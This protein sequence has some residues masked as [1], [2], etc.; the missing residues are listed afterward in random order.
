[1]PK[2]TLVITHERSGT[3]LLINC[4]NYDQKG[5]FYTVGYSENKKDFHLNGYKH[6]TYKDIMSNAYLP[7]SVSKSH[8]QAEFMEE[9]LYFLFKKYSVI[10]VKREVKDVLSSYYKFMPRPDQI[11]A[12]PSLEEWIFCKPDDIGRKFFNPYFPDPHVITEPENYVHRWFL[13]TNGWLKH[14]DKM[15]VVNYEDMLND[16][17]NQKEKIE[18]YIGKKIAPK[19]PDVHDKSL[20]N[21]GPVKGKIG[22][23]KEVMSVKLIEKIEDC[24]SLYNIKETNEKG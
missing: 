8:H 18:N 23:H 3:H 20:P 11:P 4:I 2:P 16:Y 9:Y 22:G 17:P 21:F 14:K 12:F 24:L 15:L 19:I 5:Q 10:Y 1:M 6:T 7:N 13:H